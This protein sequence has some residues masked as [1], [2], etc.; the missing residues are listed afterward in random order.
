M[1]LLERHLTRRTAIQPS[2]LRATA[3]NTEMRVNSDGGA[4]HAHSTVR[5]QPKFRSGNGVRYPRPRCSLSSRI[6]AGHLDLIEIP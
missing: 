3:C 4:H 6:P 2:R 5:N 1:I